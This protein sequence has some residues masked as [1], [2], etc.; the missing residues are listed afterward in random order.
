MIAEDEVLWY[1]LC[2]QEG[3]LPES[4]IS[5]YSCWKLIFRE[6]RAREH[7]LR[8]NWKVG[9]GLCHSLPVE[10]Q[11]ARTRES[12]PG[13]NPGSF[14]LQPELNC[15]K[16]RE[17]SVGSVPS[18]LGDLLPIVFAISNHTV[19]EH[20]I[21]QERKDELEMPGPCP[22]MLRGL[23]VVSAAPFHSRRLPGWTRKAQ[24]PPECKRGAEEAF[25][26]QCKREI[27][28]RL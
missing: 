1:R 4:S 11:P 6:C 2:Q 9:P 12:K 16:Q 7:M 25:S 5:D 3:H 13:L 14:R 18:A 24:G 28:K 21:L 17:M 10:E 15:Q 26:S 8:T 19:G 23:G 20:P 22:R 27:I